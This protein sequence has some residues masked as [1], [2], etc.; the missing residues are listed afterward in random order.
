MSNADTD[1]EYDVS[2]EIG[3]VRLLATDTNHDDHCFSDTEISAFL[4]LESASVKRAAA[5]ALETVASN[6]ALTLKVI[7]LLE[8][9]TD[10]AKTSDALLKR[11]A[12][13]RAQ[14]DDDELGEDG[15]GFDIAEMVV[16][17]FT[18]RQ[19]TFGVF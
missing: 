10:G 3:Q 15:G 2:T 7:K 13:L 19:R 8:L 16:D 6:E 5:L 1:F 18:A 12:A 11:A 4:T 14:A 9:Q 17:P